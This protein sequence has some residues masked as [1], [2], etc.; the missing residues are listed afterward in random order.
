M[1]ITFPE[2]SSKVPLGWIPLVH[3]EGSRYF[4]NEEKRTFTEMNIC[5]EQ[6]HGRIE[7][8]MKYLLSGLE[9]LVEQEE[10]DLDMMQVDL[11]LE[12]KDSDKSDGSVVCCYY[13]V[14]HRG[15]CLFWLVEFNVKDILENC[16]GVKSLSHIRLAIQAQYWFTCKLSNKQRRLH[17]TYFPSLCPVSQDHVNDVK[18]MLIHAMCD[19]ITSKQSSALGDVIELKDYISVVD[20]IKSENQFINFHGENCV[21]LESGQTVHGWEYKPSLLMIVVAPLLFLDPVT[22]VQ[23]LH[24]VFVDEIASTARW[25]A[26]SSKLKG[27]LQDSNLLATVLLNVNVGFLAINTV[28]RGGRSAIQMASYLSLVT[29]VGSI[30]LGIFLVW[31]EK[32]SGDNTAY[33]A[34]LFASRLH[35]QK[36]GLE[37]L[38]IIYSVPKALLMWGM[39]FFFVA[40]SIDW[41]GAGDTTSRAVVGT[42]ISIVFVMI[43]NG[44]IRI[45]EGE[46]WWWRTVG[47]QLS[48]LPA[49]TWKHIMRF[50]EMTRGQRCEPQPDP[51]DI[52]LHTGL[53]QAN[54]EADASMHRI[55]IS[56]LTPSRDHQLEI[57]GVNG[58]E[59]HPNSSIPPTWSR[60]PTA[61]VDSP[62]KTQGSNPTQQLGD[63][64]QTV[65]QDRS[66][67]VAHCESD[68]IPLGHVT[69]PSCSA[70][71]GI[72]ETAVKTKDLHSYALS[73]TATMLS[74]TE[75][76]TSIEI[77]AN[78]AGAAISPSSHYTEHMESARYTDNVVEEPEELDY[79]RPSSSTMPPPK[80]VA[81]SA[82]NGSF[83]HAPVAAKWTLQGSH[84]IEEYKD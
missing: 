33:E 62:L 51:E 5:D 42:V 19:H 77:E 40:F 81:R 25:N 35:D 11:V 61:F 12:L 64:I 47:Q 38:A 7:Y 80:I 78:D 54:V 23:K 24:R 57:P 26:L 30:V 46:R 37:K 52:S 22:Q 17:W 72:V 16:K 18:D 8:H 59:D 41:C 58:H 21:R 50:A 76:R 55:S 84:D 1:K 71:E 14:N 6:I 63:Y 68:A 73:T 28:D 32:T 29:S 56:H 67:A 49:H 20:G 45:R 10:L 36:H 82:T 34:V 3:P 83:R 15:R 75:G 4:L 69:A 9:L 48:S 60:Q 43:S 13:F 65:S 70:A 2:Y 53:S 44:I 79:P 31:H 66:T 39:L 27:Q 74:R